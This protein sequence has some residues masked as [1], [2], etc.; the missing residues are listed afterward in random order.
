MQEREYDSNNYRIEPPMRGRCPVCACYHDPK[1][2]HFPSSTYYI[3]RFFQKYGRRP[4]WKDAMAH[5][6]PD[7]YAR[8]K[9][10]LVARGIWPKED[11]M[12]DG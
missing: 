3:M 10:E 1:E 6:P 5:C 12:K 9:H 4:T 11:N 8:H 7:V 2:P